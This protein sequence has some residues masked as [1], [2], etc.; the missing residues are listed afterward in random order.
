[1]ADIL[2]CKGCQAALRMRPEFA[3]KKLRCPRC[4]TTVNVPAAVREPAP[5]D[6]PPLLPSD[7]YH[8]VTASVPHDTDPVEAPRSRRVRDEDDDDYEDDESNPWQ[9][10]PKCG[11]EESERVR[12]TW[13]GSFYGPALFNHVECPECGNTYNG[14][15]GSSNTIP[16]AMFVMLSAALIMG[17]I[18]TITWIILSRQYN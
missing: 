9:P 7:S 12:W 18:G 11:A 5:S 13:W 15:T 16:A 2:R 4:K 3:G 14:R 10:C 8:G 17:L 1:M 6:D